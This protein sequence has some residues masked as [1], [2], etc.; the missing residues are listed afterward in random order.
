MEKPKKEKI[1]SFK[2]KIFN[3]GKTATGLP[4]DVVVTDPN[5]ATIDEEKE[6]TGVFTFGRFNPPTVGH[7]KLIHKVESVSKE[8]G[9]EA[10]IVASHSENTS[11]DPLP[12]SKKLGYLKK[13]ASSSTHVS[14]SSKEAP[15][16][17]HIAKKLHQAGHKHLV[18]VAGSDRV[19][20]Y[21]ERLNKYNGHPDHYNFK[22][23]K[24]VSAGARDPDAEGVEGMSGTKMRSLA[25]AGK[26]D[27]FKAGLPKSL[28][29]HAKEIGNHIRTIGEEIELNE[30]ADI[31]QRM[32]RAMLMKRNKAKVQRAREL[33]RTRLANVKQ[34]RRRSLKRAKQM[35]RQR[36]AGQRGA[37]Y[38]SL[39][40][41]DKIAVDRMLDKKKGQIIRIANKITPRVKRD[42][43][44]R[45]ASVAAGKRVVNTKL[46]L[47]AGDIISHKEEKYLM[48][49]AETSQ[50]PIDLLRTIFMRGKSAYA[51]V[52]PPNVSS[53]QYAFNRLA[54]FLNKGRSFKEDDKDVAEAAKKM[55]GEDPCWDGYEMVGTKKKGGNEVPNCVPKAKK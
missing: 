30:A 27:E 52:N 54:S 41:T 35:L 4:A 32:K 22:S 53:S 55:K 48:E 21:K 10:H 31:K 13:V 3:G 17:L 38:S 49:K 28:H 24:V 26:H 18:M 7:E 19:D 44:R 46:P 36:M 39:S 16:F 42:E 1:Q 6:S 2:E 47:V 12:Q 50:L 51:N 45:L 25:R 5:K 14:G 33:S 9:G 29:P 15:N 40:M 23:I 43:I 20:E 34:I 37:S 8:H 11:K